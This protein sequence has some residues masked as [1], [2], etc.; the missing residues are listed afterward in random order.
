MH[1]CVSFYEFS[2]WYP[3]LIRI[4]RIH[5]TAANREVVHIVWILFS[6]R[7]IM[8]I[9]WRFAHVSHTNDVNWNWTSFVDINKVVWTAQY[10]S[11]IWTLVIGG[12]LQDIDFIN[13]VTSL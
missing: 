4:L 2:Q 9:E 12:Y 3:Q 1:T 5:V 11:A 6:A 8:H 13:F 7:Q 10:S